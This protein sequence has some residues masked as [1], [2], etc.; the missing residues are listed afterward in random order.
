M[1]LIL[2]ELTL[3]QNEYCL[4]RQI[5]WRNE[6][7]SSNLT[8]TEDLTKVIVGVSGNYFVYVTVLFDV[9]STSDKARS[10]V[11]EEV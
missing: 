5:V 6:A 3:Q 2:P 9:P 1:Y 10:V 8:L 11:F 4:V 7:D